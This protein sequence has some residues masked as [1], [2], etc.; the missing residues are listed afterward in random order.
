MGAVFDPDF[1]GSNITLSNGNRT[2]TFSSSTG[3]GEGAACLAGRRN[4]GKYAVAFQLVTPPSVQANGIGFG[5]ADATQP[6]DEWAGESNTGTT[7]WNYA[8]NTLN[9]QHD[10]NGANVDVVVSTSAGNPTPAG[11]QY[12]ICYNFDTGRMFVAINGTW[13]GDNPNT[14]PSGGIPMYVTGALAPCVSNYLNNTAVSVLEPSDFSYPSIIPA[15]YTQGWP[16]VTPGAQALF[17]MGSQSDTVRVME[18]GMALSTWSSTQYG[19]AAT[20]YP[21]TSG[22]FYEEFVLETMTAGDTEFYIGFSN[23]NRVTSYVGSN[24][25]SKGLKLRRTSTPGVQSMY[26]GAATTVSAGV[27]GYVAG[28]VFSVL[29][30]VSA[31]TFSMWKNGTSIISGA[32]LQ[33]TGDVRLAATAFYNGTTLRRRLP[34]SMTYAGT[35]GVGA[36]LGWQPDAPAAVNGS[37]SLTL[38]SLAGTSTGSSPVTAAVSRTLGSLVVAAAGGAP[39]INGQVG[40]VLGLLTGVAAGAQLNKG[41]VAVSL[42]P[43][44]GMSGGTSTISGAV[45]A[46]LGG[47]TGAAA[48]SSSITGTAAGTLGSLGLTATATAPVVATA[49]GTLSA[50]TLVAS[51]TAVAGVAGAVSATLGSLTLASAATAPISGS[52]VS[53]L[54]PLGVSASATSRVSGQVSSTLGPLGISASGGNASAINGAVAATLGGLVGTSTAEAPAAGQMAATLGSLAVLAAGSSKVVGTVAKALG[55]LSVGATAQVPGN[56]SVAASLG[57]LE[58]VS[59]GTTKEVTTGQLIATL[60]SMTGAATAAAIVKGSLE[61]IL[62]TLTGT[63]GGTA[64]IS[65]QM[66]GTLAPLTAV[67]TGYA[68]ITG[69][70]AGTLGEL[71]ASAQGSARV[72]VTVDQLLGSLMCDAAAFAI[73]VPDPPPLVPIIGNRPDSF[74]D[75][76]VDRPDTELGLAKRQT[77]TLGIAERA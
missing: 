55:S 76:S 15:A 70:V 28:D 60:G 22:L 68:P 12:L 39:P 63:G 14:T 35:L 16:E 27:F 49:G 40:A 65:G 13:Y 66:F 29:V 4:T 73:S 67:A 21:K 25:N 41:V 19:S 18:D 7:I 31:R 71:A 1:C 11:K 6:Y 62:G 75:G 33:F 48:G 51:G 72:A 45:S 58:V 20:E 17:T 59:T 74:A 50:L 43:L 30:D 69:Q 36:T 32:A 10:F 42:A 44:T 8:T 77:S 47:L 52:L 56:G 46:A 54:A 57:Q 26:N 34:G 5:L 3:N 23:N 53:T 2:A 24:A 64:E 61:R 38:G 9:Y 37:V